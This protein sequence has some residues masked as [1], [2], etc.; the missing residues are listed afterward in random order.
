MIIAF[1]DVEER[2]EG[3]ATGEDVTP[4]SGQLGG[5]RVP[6]LTGQLEEH[7]TADVGA[8]AVRRTVL[9]AQVPVM[10]IPMPEDSVGEQLRGRGCRSGLG[11]AGGG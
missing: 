2:P 4:T 1:T 7:I 10:L 9:D 5:R 3:A 8:A 6:I 11:R